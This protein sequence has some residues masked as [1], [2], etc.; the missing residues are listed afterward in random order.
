M[1]LGVGEVADHQ[2]RAG[3]LV[4]AHPALPAQALG[5]PRTLNALLENPA[6]LDAAIRGGSAAAA[7]SRPALRRLLASVTS[8]SPATT[9]S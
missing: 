6:G 9:Q 4:G 2:A 7:G 5:L 8:G 3:S 1:A